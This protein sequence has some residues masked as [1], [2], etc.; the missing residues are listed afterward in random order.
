MTANETLRLILRYLNKGEISHIYNVYKDYCAK[1]NP[2]NINNK[3]LIDMVEKGKSGLVIMETLSNDTKALIN[4]D[5][6]DID[7][8]Y[9]DTELRITLDALLKEWEN[10]NL[11][12]RHNIPL[13]NKLLLHGSTGNGKTTLAKY[14]AKLFNLPFISINS[15]SM[16]N[17]KLG[18]T[19]QN[20]NNIFNKINGKCVLFWD[21]IDSIAKVR[22]NSND[23]IA[24][25]NDRIVN[26]LL[27][28]IEKMN[29]DIIFI[30]ATN[31]INILDSAFIRRFD[32]LIEI[33]PPS[34]IDKYKY[35][36][37]LFIQFNINTVDLLWDIE[38]FKE[39]HSYSDIKK[40]VTRISR[41][42]I[43]NRVV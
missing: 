3:L 10:S 36:T 30:G 23:S 6:S 41:N 15:D 1:L 22:N 2:N 37:N 12:S 26:S 11:L 21:E 43:L 5:I 29:S 24:I 35:I 27:I 42:Y 34:I 17:S 19:G 39:F 20:I 18:A 4:H 14:I 8:V 40:E 28:N 25:E 38:D 33:E 9:I 7:N 32:E 13:R 31:R 16:I